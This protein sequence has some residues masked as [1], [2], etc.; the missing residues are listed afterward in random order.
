ML[1]AFAA[2]AVLVVECGGKEAE[3][4]RSEKLGGREDGVLVV[5]VWGGLLLMGALLEVL[6]YGCC[7]SGKFKRKRGRA[8]SDRYIEERGRM[9]DFED[10]KEVL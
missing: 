5:G 6:C 3:R 2:V 8:Q 1:P 7:V 4:R 9:R 10:V